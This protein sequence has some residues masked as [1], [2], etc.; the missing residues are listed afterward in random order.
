MLKRQREK[1]LQERRQQKDARRLEAKERKSSMPRKTG[2]ED[3]D[4]AG[5]IPGPQRL[6]HQFDSTPEEQ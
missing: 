5:I 6:P 4:I 2:D 3:P 1:L